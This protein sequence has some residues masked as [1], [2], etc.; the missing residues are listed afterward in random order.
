MADYQ[1]ERFSYHLDEEAIAWAERFDGE[2]VLLTNVSD[3]SAAGILARSVPG[4]HRARLP[5]A[6]KRSGDRAGVPPPAARMR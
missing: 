5:R 4:R 1:T 2:L 6:Q 3:F